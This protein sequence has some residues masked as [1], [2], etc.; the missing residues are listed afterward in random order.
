MYPASA[1]LSPAAIQKGCRR[2]L[3][4]LRRVNAMSTFPSHFDVL[5]IGAGHGGA[6]AAIALRQPKFAGSIGLPGDEPDL[7][8]ERRQPRS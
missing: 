7:P 6:Q 5:I 2:G 4:R 8:Y 1:A 3:F